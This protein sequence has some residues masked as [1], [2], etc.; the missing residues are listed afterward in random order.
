MP[1]TDATAAS[2]P[3][4][5]WERICRAADFD[6]VAEADVT[7]HHHGLTAGGTYLPGDGGRTLVIEIHARHAGAALRQEQCGRASDPRSWRPVPGS[8]DDGALVRQSQIDHRL[9]CRFVD[10][11]HLPPKLK[12]TSRSFSL[13]SH[14]TDRR[15]P[16]SQSAN[17]SQPHT[18]RASMAHAP[19]DLLRL[20]KLD[21]HRY[22]GLPEHDGDLR[23]VVFGGQILAQ[24]IMAAHADRTDPAHE[25]RSDKE[26]KSIH[27]IFARA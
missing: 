10:A 27:A 21:D 4:V 11:V 9:P 12:S 23:N 22:R 15:R 13:E 14:A 17:R 20:E 18:E 7:G 16:R 3:P 2:A 25:Q 1:S 19:S 24:M 5:P 26:V 8:H 6:L